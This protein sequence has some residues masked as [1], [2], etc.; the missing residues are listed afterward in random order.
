MTERLQGDAEATSVEEI[1]TEALMLFISSTKKLKTASNQN[2]K[3]GF[4]KR[5]R[6][7][8]ADIK[9]ALESFKFCIK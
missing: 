2:F 3:K 6:F 5:A 8:T 9:H 4:E 7:I 1:V